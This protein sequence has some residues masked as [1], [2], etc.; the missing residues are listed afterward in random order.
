[1]LRLPGW[2]CLLY[3]IVIIS[4]LPISLRAD[5][6]DD[7]EAAPLDSDVQVTPANLL[8]PAEPATSPASPREGPDYRSIVG[9]SF[10]FLFL[11]QAFR[12]A[13]EE[14][15]RHPHVSFIGG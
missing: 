9:Q 15:T 3:C 13:T 12:Y 11:E 1:M 8:L 10:R 2:S 6:A 4:I 5:P 7:P 14:G